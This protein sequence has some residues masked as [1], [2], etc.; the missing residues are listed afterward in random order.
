MYF[1][2]NIPILL[3]FGVFNMVILLIGFLDNS[4]PN[5]AVTYIFLFNLLIFIVYII[6]DYTRKQSFNNELLK[7][8]SL[9][10]IAV[11]S[12]GNTPAQR[13]IYETLEELRTEHQNTV[14][15]ESRKTRENLDELTRFIHDMK[16]PVTTMKLMIDDLKGPDRQKLAGEWTRLNGM[17]NEILY[18]KRLPNI[19]NDLYIE[20][21]SLET[22]LNTSIK[23]LRDICMEKNIGFDIH[24]HEKNVHTD[25]KWLQF[26]MDQIITNSVKY[27]S[28]NDIVIKSQVTAGRMQLSVTDYG[29]G[30]KEKDIHRIFEAG[31]TSTS[32]HHDDQS[33][34]MGMYLTKEVCDALAIN[35]DVTSV[36]G[37]Y[38][39]VTLTFSKANEFSKITMK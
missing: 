8:G 32:D 11:M 13:H 37:D 9:N 36:Y 30:I 12:K 27:S 18:L 5:I 33:T 7:L 3:L 17:L 34:G 6:W 10:D 23:K 16:M 35:I 31:F 24:L 4:I 19:K 26:V 25:R 20:N 15:K 22:I 2:E 39:T 21:M 1:K 29:R 14:D 38:T 28:D